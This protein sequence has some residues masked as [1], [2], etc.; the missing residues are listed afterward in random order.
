MFAVIAI[1]AA[2]VLLLIP[3]GDFGDGGAWLAVLPMLFVGLISPLSLL[4]PL[5]SIY[6]G[7]TPEAPLLPSSFQRPPPC[8]LG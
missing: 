7:R 1:A 6:L 3:H 5:A 2:L 4:S 8:S